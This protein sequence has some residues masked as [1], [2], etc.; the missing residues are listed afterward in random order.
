MRHK[1][2]NVAKFES[3]FARVCTVQW[4][5]V[6]HRDNGCQA[7][8][9]GKIHCKHGEGLV[10]RLTWKQRLKLTLSISSLAGP[11]TCYIPHNRQTRMIRL[12]GTHHCFHHTR[13]K[14]PWPFLHSPQPDNSSWKVAIFGRSV[15][16]KKGLRASMSH[17][18][19]NRTRNSPTLDSLTQTNITTRGICKLK[20]DWNFCTGI[21][22]TRKNEGVIQ[23]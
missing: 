2:I 20:L 17:A 18:T 8:K 14:V 19:H 21:E 23:Y 3:L 5:R 15:G 6:V 10:L 4:D 11:T 1:I 9:E 7:P 12:S 16:C 22:G 13:H